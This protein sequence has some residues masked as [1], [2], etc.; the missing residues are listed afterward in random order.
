MA[1]KRITP[2]TPKGSGKAT[3]DRAA[4]RKSLKKISRKKV[5]KKK[6]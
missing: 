4:E 6:H 3:V 1:D 2:K 5:S